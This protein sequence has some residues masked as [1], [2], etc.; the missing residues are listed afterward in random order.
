MVS[1]ERKAA[2]ILGGVVL[3]EGTWLA[4]NL[5][6]ATPA[7]FLGY[8]GF[9][10]SA[11]FRAWA[12]ALIVAYIFIAYASR[13][14]SVRTNLVRFG[15]LKLLALSVAIAAGF[16]EEVIF[17]K[18]LMDFCDYLEWPQVSQVLVSA[19]AYGAVHA[20]WGLLRRNIAVAWGAMAAT[21][22][23][24]FLLAL[25][26]LLGGRTLAPCIVSHMLINVFTE[27]GLVLAAVRGE[28]GQPPDTA[29][30]PR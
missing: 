5:Y 27:P 30:S 6:F 8:C 4:A 15:G 17:R 3:S 9:H 11:G 19:L 16:C 25:V 28:M 7:F 14:P 26:Y 10:T 20:M 1:D 2:L 29:R 22:S 13:F 21:G 23:L 12:M 18:L 24:G